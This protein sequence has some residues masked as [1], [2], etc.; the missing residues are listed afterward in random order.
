[1]GIVN[2]EFAIKSENDFT[3]T[4]VEEKSFTHL[5][6]ERGVEYKIVYRVQ[7]VEGAWSLP[8]EKTFKIDEVP[9]NLTAKVKA[10]DSRF[11]VD[12]MPIT[13]YYQI[14][15]IETEYPSELKL[16]IALCDGDVQVGALMT[17]GFDEGV[18]AVTDKDNSHLV[19][20]HFQD[21]QVPKTLADKAYQIKIRAIDVANS[22]KSEELV[23]DVGVRTPI[24]PV[25]E[26]NEV[27]IGGECVDVS[28][29]SS[30]YTDT[31]DM[32]LYKDTDEEEIISMVFDHWNY[33]EIAGIQKRVGKVWVHTHNVPTDIEEG[34]YDVVFTGTVNTTPKKMESVLRR[35]H[36]MPLN[37][38][39]VTITGAWQHWR[40]QEDL[41]SEQMADMPYRFL[42]WEKIYITAKTIGDP[43][44]VF[45]RM[46]E[47]LEAMSFTDQNGVTYDYEDDFGDEVD[48]P[49]KLK[50]QGNDI[51]SVEYI[52]PLAPSTLSWDDERL[53]PSYEVVVTAKKNDTT[54]DCVFSES[55]GNGI[56]IT[57]NTTDLIYVQPLPDRR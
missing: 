3:W 26:L 36:V 20:W 52:L 30:I 53:R 28:C 42:S 18:S 11:S 8:L 34:V 22:S 45:V 54:I 46:S 4:K 24:Q 13:E 25:P 33:E 57:G 6:I 48:F 44:S 17:V 47:P 56:E 5:Q 41:F 1:K 49:L 10:R 51:W 21:L 43:D 50:N 12:A 27:F 7:D 35:V 40:G 29:T 2:Y 23:L 9:I 14:Y 37:F 16:E 55:N 31:L 15:D 39:S 38:E 32:T 19:R